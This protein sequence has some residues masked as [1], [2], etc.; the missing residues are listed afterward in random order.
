M[1]ILGA[2]VL[3]HPPVI[4]PEVGRGSEH[5]LKKTT[6]AYIEAARWLAGLRPETVIITTP[7]STVYG[8]YFH[9]SPGPT[10][11]G[12]MR[13]FRAP[14]LR[15]TADY[16]EEFVALLSDIA[17]EREVPAGT[18]GERNRALDH[19][20]LI[21]L[22][23]LNKFYSGYRIVRIGLS[24][25][26]PICHY[27]LGQSIAETAD[28]LGRQAVV[29]A[30]GDLSHKLLEDGPYGY[31]AEGSEFD[32][33]ITDLLRAGDF[34]S[35]LEV[36][37]GFA[38]AAA[39]CGLRSFQIMAGALDRKAVSHKLLS[40]E[41]PFGVGYAV[42]LF[43]VGGE[44]ET[45]AFGEKYE[46]SERA[47]LSACRE[48][49]DQ[50]VCLARLSLETYIE[51]GKPA[52]LP[53]N[54]SEE[55]TS[56]KAGVFVSLKKHGKLRGCIGTISALTENVA[57]EVM[58]NAVSAAVNDPRF[59]PVTAGELGD[60]EYSVDVLGETEAVSSVDK[61]DEK[62]YG[63]IVRSGNR[64]G[65]L[66]P[67]LEGVNSVEKQIEIARKKARIRE[68]EPVELHRFEVVRHY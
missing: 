66:L 34:L 63:V 13:A 62:R 60:L 28:K 56:T 23:F 58:K 42:A 27:R 26:S 37:E 18:L 29:I 12:D 22:Y 3:P 40:Y 67:G 16:D 19:G 8:D 65:L 21:P 43:E 68:N 46:D 9:I 7:H 48:R 25:Q 52:V 50:Y 17:G 47:R 31:V 2:A 5:N 36:T 20:T 6:E 57:E 4:L 35:L 54:I 61:L 33:Q 44:D 45:R 30:S 64:T 32:K 59:D 53:E 39:E 1:P 15:V 51:T 10:A 49:E 38:D 55:M 11:E 14:E 24:G 41:G